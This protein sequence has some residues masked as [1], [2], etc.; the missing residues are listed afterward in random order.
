MDKFV[1]A[2]NSATTNVSQNVLDG[3]MPY[4]T[5]HYGNPSSTIYR[6]GQKTK[7]AIDKAAQQ[8]ANAINCESMEIFFTSGGTEA[9]N[10]AIKGISN[11]MAKR[12]KKHIITTNFEH[13]AVLH[14][15]EE[16]SK[17][18]FDVTFLPVNEE[19]FITVEQVKDAIREDTALVTIIYANNEIGTIQPINEIGALCRENGIIF[20]TDAVQAIGNVHIDVKKQNIDLLSI[21]GHKIH[22]LKGVGVLYIRKGIVA[23]NIIHGGGQQRGKRPGTE[24]VAGIVSLGIAIED[25]VNNIDNKVAYVTKLKNKLIDGLLTIPKS[26]LN[27]G[28]DNRLC[29]NVNVSFYACEGEALLLYLDQLGICASSG[30]ACTTAALDPSHVLLAI[31]LPHEIAHGSLRFSLNEQNTEQEV[32][33]IIDCV[34]KVVQRVRSMSPLWNE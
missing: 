1:Y 3:I 33:Y 7:L 13:H 6:L 28:I 9:D 34:K 15:C 23:S 17:L 2:D 24:N 30:S 20:H 26:K 16:L 29:G 19:G 22:A 10:W 12:G 4:L 27:G 21:S 11:F 25:A 18:G 8:V 32:D 5:E 14:P 31:G